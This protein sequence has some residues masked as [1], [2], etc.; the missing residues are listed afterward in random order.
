MLP[1]RNGGLFVVGSNFEI[2]IILLKL[3]NLTYK[4]QP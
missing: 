2:Y 4:L 1:E 3:E